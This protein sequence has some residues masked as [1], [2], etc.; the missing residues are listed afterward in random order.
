ML[1]DILDN[2]PFKEEPSSKSEWWST[3]IEE[4]DDELILEQKIIYTLSAEKLSMA[5]KGSSIYVLL[6]VLTVILA[7]GMLGLIIGL[8][9]GWLASSWWS[10]VIVIGLLLGSPMMFGVADELKKKHQDTGLRNSQLV[11]TSQQLLLRHHKPVAIKDILSGRRSADDAKKVILD[12]QKSKAIEFELPTEV[13][14]SNVLKTIEELK[15]K[16]TQVD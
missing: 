8:S 16:S 14:A 15:Y 7:I 4:D 6:E 10:V 1:N 5:K 9:L 12:I 13:E 11:L 3:F 2:D